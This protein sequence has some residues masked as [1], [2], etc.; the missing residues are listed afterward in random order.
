MGRKRKEVQ[1]PPPEKQF[2]QL[3]RSL[4]IHRR[5]WEVFADFCELAALALYSAVHRDP[6]REARAQPIRERYTDQQLEIFPKLLA[7]VVE[8]LHRDPSNDFL[9]VRFTEL[10]LANHWK[11]QF[12]TPREVALAVAHFTLGSVEELR[13]RVRQTHFVT[14]QDPAVGAGSL[15]IAAAAV[16]RAAGLNPQHHLHVTGVDVDRTAAYMAYI[17]LSLLGIPGVVVLGDSLTLDFRESWPTLA[18]KLGMWDLRLA[19]RRMRDD[20]RPT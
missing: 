9:G 2:D 3:F 10:E 5:A 16:V 17:Q 6:E 11:G 20:G 15:L 13:E 7:C 8:G 4:C 18:H 19:V 12:F 14:I 1:A